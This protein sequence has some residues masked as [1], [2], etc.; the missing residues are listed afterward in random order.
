MKFFAKIG[1]AFRVKDNHAE[2]ERLRTINAAL[3]RNLGTECVL[4]G[5]KARAGLF[6]TKF[7]IIVTA[8]PGLDECEFARRVGM[9]L[10]EELTR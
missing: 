6:G 10:M 1:R 2:C 4:I 5:A 8:T 3:S 7:N 9:V